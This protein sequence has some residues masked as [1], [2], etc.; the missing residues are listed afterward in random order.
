MA[1]LSFVCI[2]GVSTKDSPF[3]CSM[4][5][6][7]GFKLSMPSLDCILDLDDYKTTLITSLSQAWQLAKDNIEK[8]QMRHKVHYDHKPK[9]TKFQV[10]DCVLVHM[11]AE[12]QGTQRKLSRPSHNKSERLQC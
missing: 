1:T 11:P 12:M 3:S 7:P 9:E 2:S 4:A 8:A 5:E 10:G 6:T